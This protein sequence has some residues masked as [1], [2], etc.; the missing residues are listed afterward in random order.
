MAGP[1][2]NSKLNGT[3]MKPTIEDKVARKLRTGFATKTEE[4]DAKYAIY[5]SKLKSIGMNETESTRK[6]FDLWDDTND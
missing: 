5:V 4:Q 3:R 2:Q 1:E 6:S